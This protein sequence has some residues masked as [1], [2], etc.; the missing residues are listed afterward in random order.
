MT[1]ARPTSSRL[2]AH[3]R[4]DA[5]ALD[6]QE[7]EDRDQHRARGLLPDRRERIL[8]AAPEVVGE[9]VGLEGD[10]GDHDEDQDRH[11]L[12]DGHDVVDDRGILDAAQDQE[13]EQ[14]HTDRRH[15]HR[16]NR[17]AG[18]ECGHNARSSWP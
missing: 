10:D 1:V 18:A 2:R 5:G 3:P 7:H 6:A 11:D 14:P 12:G 13:D 4:V 15:D 9:D 17:V 16:S 8:V